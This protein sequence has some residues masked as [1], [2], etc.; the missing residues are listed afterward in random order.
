MANRRV[1]GKNISQ[2][3]QSAKSE[4]LV[5]MASFFGGLNLSE[6]GFR[7]SGNECPKLTNL[8]V[9]N[10]LLCCRDGQSWM[11]NPSTPS[12]GTGHT[13]Y[14]P[15][16]GYFIAHISTYLYAFNIP[17]VGYATPTLIH[18]NVPQ[19][20]GTFF[21]YNGDL[22]YKTSGAYYKITATWNESAQRWDFSV[23]SMIGYV[24]VILINAEPS[25]GSGTMYQPE[26]RYS[27]YKTVWY[28]SDGSAAYHLPVLA[29]SI[30]KV[31]VNG[32][33]TTAYT[34]N[35]ATGI[36]T[37]TNP[38]A[39]AVPPVTNNVKITYYLMNTDAV[40]AFHQCRFATL[41]G[42]ATGELC[43]VMGGSTAQPNAY[44]W[45]G[46]SDIV[47]D[48]SY[49]PIPNYQL[50]GDISDPITGFGK[51]QSYLVVFKE[52]SL[53][54]CSQGTEE[55]SG[56]VYI[57]MAYIPINSEIGCSYPA[58]IHLV[59]NNLVWVSRRLGVCTLL[60]TSAAFENNVV[61]I[62]RKVNEGVTQSGLLADLNN[63]S[64][65]EVCAG[66]NG[67]LYFV[68]A[69][70]HAWVWDYSISARAD[71]SWFYFN[72]VQA[73]DF[74]Y[75]SDNDRLYHLNTLGRITYFDRTF[76]DYGA[77]IN[78]EFHSR[79][80]NFDNYLNEK[81][82]NSVI[83]AL[84]NETAAEIEVNYVTDEGD[85]ADLT[86]LTVSNPDRRFAQVFRRRPMARHVQH[87]GVKLTDYTGAHDMA[88][89]SIEVYFNYQGNMR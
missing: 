85:F 34:Y 16:H 88:I 52:H 27:A 40:Q 20:R 74:C 12:L 61:V 44:F 11:T 77:P 80:L 56:R 17:S 2:S 46:N 76:S 50:A 78:K 89:S 15:W 30:S 14:G 47:M 36:L 59:E 72:P 51:Q 63:V 29:T 5:N 82:V 22:Y 48:P 68:C 62:S 75:D 83:F 65:D 54:R 3:A 49:W 26:N 41:Y 84:C 6:P 21:E 18:L 33:Q 37:F 31:F 71:P 81:N 69:N 24:P 43:I 70:Q 9:K 60:D 13:F 86:N 1:T 4:Y 45:N 57:D 23:S 19:V 28:T 42:G 7:L 79:V 73:I 39:A 32:V 66:A 87:F 64:A 35:S 53:G 8:F 25:T 55:I 38:P 10:G 58:T 67:D